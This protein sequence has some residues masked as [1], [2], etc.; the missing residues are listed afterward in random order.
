MKLKARDIIPGWPKGRSTS[1]FGPL[2]SSLILWFASI[3]AREDECDK[4]R[5]A[6]QLASLEYHQAQQNLLHAYFEAYRSKPEESH[7][8]ML[9][10]VL[11]TPAG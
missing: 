2:N 4:L 3:R 11:Q 7:L 1:V 5:F 6:E 9:P 10:L 8:L